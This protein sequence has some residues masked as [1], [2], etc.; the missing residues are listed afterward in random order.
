MLVGSGTRP[1]SHWFHR[2]VVLDD[3]DRPPFRRCAR[4]ACRAQAAGTQQA[5]QGLVG[6]GETEILDLVEQ[7]RC[8]QVRVLGQAGGAVGGERFEP[9]PTGR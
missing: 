6:A 5:G 7:G 9:V 3:R 2:P 1:T 8:P 4:L